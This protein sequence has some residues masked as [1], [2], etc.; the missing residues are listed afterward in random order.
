M[1][2]TVAGLDVPW[3]DVHVFQADERVAPQADADRNLAHLRESLLEHGR[4]RL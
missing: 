1:L 2:R 4:L 3:K